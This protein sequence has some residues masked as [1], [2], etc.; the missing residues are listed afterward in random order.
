MRPGVACQHCTAS[1]CAIYERRPVEPCREFVCAWLMQPSPLPDH[2]RPDQ[3]GAIVKWRQKWKQWWIIQALPVGETIPQATLDYLMM[4]ARK[5]M[6]PL[7][8]VSNEFKDGECVG[9]FETGFG[10]PAFLEAVKNNDEA[11]GGMIK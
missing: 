7:L 10:P 11:S 3:C 9:H 5:T 4:V 6:M 2:M 1:G 8:I